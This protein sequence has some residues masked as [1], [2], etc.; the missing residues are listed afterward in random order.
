MSTDNSGLLSSLLPSLPLPLPSPHS[1]P[2]GLHLISTVAAAAATTTDDQDPSGAAAL[3]EAGVSE[4]SNNSSSSFSSNN[5]SKKSSSKGVATL[6]SAKRQ[7]Q[8][9]ECQLQGYNDLHPRKRTRLVE[10]FVNQYAR[11][12]PGD[13]AH[14]IHIFCNKRNLIPDALK[15][16]HRE[17]MHRS[18]WLIAASDSFSGEE[19]DAIRAAKSSGF[20]SWYRQIAG[21]KRT[22]PKLEPIGVSV[23]DTSALDDMAYMV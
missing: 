2:N 22:K 4:S 15:R 20:D 8:T 3:S 16:M 23:V 12:P 19:T 9:A 13:K 10:S 14:V 17:H 1:S 6:P 18:W 7:L 5:S 11:T 21:G